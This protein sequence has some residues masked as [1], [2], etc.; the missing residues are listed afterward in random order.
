MSDGYRYACC[1][2]CEHD[3][4]DDEHVD[5]HPGPHK[6]P[7]YL[8]GEPDITWPQDAPALA[9]NPDGAA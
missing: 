3:H 7:G 2:H 4:T 8:P 9:G 5:G 1:P 6:A